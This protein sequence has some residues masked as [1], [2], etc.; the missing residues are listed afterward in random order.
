MPVLRFQNRRERV[1]FSKLTCPLSF[2]VFQAIVLAS[3]FSCQKLEDSEDLKNNSETKVASGSTGQVSY[4]VD[5]EIKV[6]LIPAKPLTVKRG[7]GSDLISVDFPEPTDIRDIARYYQLISGKQVVV[8]PSL[9]IKVKIE[10]S[11]MLPKKD[12]LEF[13]V[14]SLSREGVRVEEDKGVINFYA[15]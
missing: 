8:D 14:S 15:F 12:A 9:K 3:A 7:E 6:A 11:L 5:G 1:K 2:R 4:D 13:L 10:S